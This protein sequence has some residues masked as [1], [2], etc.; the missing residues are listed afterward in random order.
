MRRQAPRAKSSLPTEHTIQSRLVTALRSQ[1]RPPVLRLA[2]PNGG[3]RHPRVALA[4]KA[5]GLE[6]GSPDLIFPYE[7]ARV[8]WLEMKRGKSGSLSDE[9][10]GMH[11]RLREMGHDVEVARDVD[12]ALALLD[13]RGLLK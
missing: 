9:Q 10:I 7:D 5:E 4:L 13:E 12:E 6:P 2:I 1:L 11:Y 3:L 8:F